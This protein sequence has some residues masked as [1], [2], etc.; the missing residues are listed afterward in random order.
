MKRP[1]FFISSTIYD[2]SDLRSAIKHFLEQQGCIVLASE[3]NDFRKPLDVHSY[4]AC[5]DAIQQADYFI[6]LVGSRVGGWYDKINHISIT[7]QE[8]RE[9]YKLHLEGRLK[10][11]NFVRTDIWNLRADR[12][13]LGSYLETLDFEA[14]EANLIKNHPTPKATN[15]EFI[16]N[17]LNEISRNRETK[18]ALNGAGPFPSGNWLHVF[19]SFRDIADVL[20]PEIFD[21]VPIDEAV[22]RRLLLS[23][24]KEVIR[25][26]LGKFK[27]GSVFSPTNSITNFYHE[28]RVDKNVLDK[29]YLSVT[30]KRWDLLSTLAIYLMNVKFNPLILPQVLS[31]SVFLRFDNVK[32]VFEEEPVYHALNLLQQEISLLNKNNT[33]ENLAIIY[34][35]TP[36][37]RLQDESHIKVDSVK[38]LAFLH[39]LLRWSNVI[40]LSKS[41]IQYLEGAPFIM[42]KVFGKSPIPD[43]NE[44]L[45]KETVTQEDVDNFIN[46]K[47]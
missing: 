39:L 30:T 14:G 40:E 12:R 22:M 44:E 26:S 5:L 42:P 36:R 29:G 46:E 7:Q 47:N 24:L 1:T 25:K 4:Q 21:G 37:R 18:E 35:H 45:E 19:N 31:S 27:E 16:I 38:F 9:A 23:E 33:S 17:F 10:I 11:I 41:I 32:G 28:H 8:Y 15:P 2:F 43:M 3:N 13:E 20:Q 34:E 6:L